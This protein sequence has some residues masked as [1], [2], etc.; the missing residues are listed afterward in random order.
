VLSFGEVE[1]VVRREIIIP[2]LGH[3]FILKVRDGAEFVPVHFNGFVRTVSAEVRVGIEVI[4]IA[5]NNGFMACVSGRDT[6]AI[7]TSDNMHWA[8]VGTRVA[9]G[10][11]GSVRG[12]LPVDGGGGVAGEGAGRALPGDCER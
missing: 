3:V 5:A 11:E 6:D 9:R 2:V 1:L 8:L 7:Y 4:K 12:V 10:G